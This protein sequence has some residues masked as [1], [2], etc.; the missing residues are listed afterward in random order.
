M[1]ATNTAA[2]AA[3]TETAFNTFKAILTHEGVRPALAYLRSLSD[4]RYIAVFRSQ[5]DKATAAVFFDRDNPDVLRTD[6]VPFCATYCHLACQTRALF[7]TTDSVLDPRLDAHPARLAVR[8]YW[9]LPIIT[10]EGDMQGTLCLYDVVPHTPAVAAAVNLELML[11]AAS[12]LQQLG[13]PPYRA[14]QGPAFR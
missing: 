7:S 14:A 1:N 2:I 6:E 9:G 5:G 13:L 3:N 10:P 4:F 12:T 11:A 8:A